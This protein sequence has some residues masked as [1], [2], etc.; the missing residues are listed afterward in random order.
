MDQEK[1]CATCNYRVFRSYEE[2]CK[3]CDWVTRKS[4]PYKFTNWQPGTGRTNDPDTRRQIDVLFDGPPG[5]EAGRFVEIESPPGT[6]I[7][8]GE[9]VDRGNGYWALRFSAPA[10]AK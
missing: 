6:S 9:W 4:G 8:F 7:R 10:D 3:S 1:S 5:P 2:P